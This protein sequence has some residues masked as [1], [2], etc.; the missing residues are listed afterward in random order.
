MIN[1]N[2]LIF[3]GILTM[4]TLSVPSAYSDTFNEQTCLSLVS[5]EQVKAITG[6]QGT[7]DVRVINAN[8][9]SLNEEIGTGCAIGFEDKEQ[10][11]VLG[12]SVSAAN[13]EQLAQSTYGELFSTSH[14][15]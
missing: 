1:H 13:S 7:I 14:Q 2:A 8:L 10:S 4:L 5:V 12:L 3:F 9:E 15:I 11:F 6:F